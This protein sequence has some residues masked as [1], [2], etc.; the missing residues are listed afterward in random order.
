MIARPL[1]DL[2]NTHS[3]NSLDPQQYLFLDHSGTLGKALLK[4]FRIT[5]LHYTSLVVF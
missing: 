5:Y 1:P 2:S 3:L 4:Q